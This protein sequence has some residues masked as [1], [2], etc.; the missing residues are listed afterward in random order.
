[1]TLPGLGLVLPRIT[2]GADGIAAVAAAAEGAGAA[3]VWLTDHLFWTGPALDV[4]GALPLVAQA[5]ST[6]TIGPLVL[7]LPLRSTAATAKSM[8]FLSTLAPARVV[9]GVGV[10][11]HE[12]E[13]EAAGLGDAY[14]RRGALLDEGIADL[15]R[16]WSGAA[17]PT[18]LAM[19]PSAD[20]PIWVGGRSERARRRAA[21]AGDGWVPHLCRAGW[22]AE[23]MAALD[24]DLAAAGRSSTAFARGALVAVSV[25]GVEPEVDPLAWLGDLYSLPPS[26]FGRAL[27][28]GT[29]DEV[30]A[31]LEHFTDAGASHVALMVAGNDPVAHLAALV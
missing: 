6:C 17:G 16:A 30:R 5:T 26:A 25:D 23:Q 4:I 14:R 29:A 20:L 2:G 21:A 31:E 12:A 9:V 22:F 1:V 19:E 3:A 24:D 8:S 13:Y 10:G 15:R 11:E 7:Q 28:R 18:G 27:A